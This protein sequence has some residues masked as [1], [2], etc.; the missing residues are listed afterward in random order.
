MEYILYLYRIV[1][2]INCLLGER[3]YL[4]M[5]ADEQPSFSHGITDNFIDQRTEKAR[6]RALLRCPKNNQIESI[7]MKPNRPLWLPL[8]SFDWNETDP[9]T[10]LC[11]A[12]TRHVLLFGTW[13]EDKSSLLT[14]YD[15]DAYVIGFMHRPAVCG[16]KS[17]GITTL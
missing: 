2:E 5:G 8:T 3:H 14:A 15:N 1:R 9:S 4:D 12:L 6:G 16:R 13:R 17:F 11:K 10:S 7:N